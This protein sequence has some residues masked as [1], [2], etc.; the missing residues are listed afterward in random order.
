MN[1][2]FDASINP[3][4]STF[5]PISDKLGKQVKTLARKTFTSG[6]LLNNQAIRECIKE[7]IKDEIIKKYGNQF[8]IEQLDQTFTEMFSK[9]FYELS[10][11]YSM[12][13]P[14]TFVIELNEFYLQL[15]MDAKAKSKNF[16]KEFNDF[17]AE[18]KNKLREEIQSELTNNAKPAEKR[19]NR[20]ADF[21]YLYVDPHFHNYDANWLAN[22]NFIA[23]HGPTEFNAARCFYNLLFSEAARKKPKVTTIIGL[24]SCLK[25]GYQDF[26]N[27]SLDDRTEEEKQITPCKELQIEDERFQLAYQLNIQNTYV[28]PGYNLETKD[29]DFP[30]GFATSQLTITNTKDI[31][32]SHNLKALLIA[33]KDGGCIKLNGNDDDTKKL[34]ENLWQISQEVDLTAVAVHCTMGVGRTGHLILMLELL[35]NYKEVFS[36]QNVETINNNI[37]AIVTRMRTNRIP[38]IHSEQQ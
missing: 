27:Y 33:V 35:K 1:S 2:H 31:T 9:R 21:Y 23:L 30:E 18:L 8:S 3:T 14:E 16:P 4:L 7:E 29:K 17:K 36:S 24:G 34:K 25:E 28:S 38:L 20:G 12:D 10:R 37:D 13:E 15:A 11:T 26:F 19:K 22:S 32:L 6:N 5:A